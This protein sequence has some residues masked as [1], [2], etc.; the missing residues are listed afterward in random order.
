MKKEELQW[1]ADQAT[2]Y[3]AIVNVGCWTGASVKTLAENTDGLVYAIDPWLDPAT[4]YDKEVADK[5][6]PDWIYSTFL[7]NME[8]LPNVIPMRTTSLE[9]AK[10]LGRNVFDMVFIDALHEYEPVRADILAWLPLI[11]KGGILCGHDYAPG[12]P[13]GVGVIKAVDELLPHRILEAGWLWRVD[14]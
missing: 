11:S 3:S 12:Y 7:K 14:V 9:A 5:M 8:G 13:W 2:R 6:T 1:L 10:A 4:V